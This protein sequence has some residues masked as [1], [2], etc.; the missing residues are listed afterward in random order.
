MSQLFYL[1]LTFYST[2]NGHVTSQTI[3]DAYPQLQCEAAGKAAK[4]NYNGGFRIEWTCV[5]AASY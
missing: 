2:F 1:V 3:P 5:P 4:D